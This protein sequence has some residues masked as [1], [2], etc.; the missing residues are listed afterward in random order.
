M[1]N[2]LSYLIHLRIRS[3]TGLSCVPLSNEASVSYLKCVLCRNTDDTQDIILL[4]HEENKN[5]RFKL[6]CIPLEFQVYIQE[7]FLENVSD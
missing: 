5:I 1:K 7:R 6:S 2:V 4:K 3:S